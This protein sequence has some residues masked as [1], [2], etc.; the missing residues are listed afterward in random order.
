MIVW[1]QLLIAIFV[2]YI[3]TAANIHH[4]RCIIFLVCDIDILI[5]FSLYWCN[6]AHYGCDSLKL[7]LERFLTRHHIR[8][9]VLS[10]TTHITL[11]HIYYLFVFFVVFFSFTTKGGHSGSQAVR[12]FHLS[13]LNMMRPSKH[14]SGI[15]LRSGSNPWT[16]L[17]TIR[18]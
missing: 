7:I 4:R 15:S 6:L 2:I 1:L 16:R 12:A 3:V 5:Y 10:L 13:R 8:L 18:C 14:L 11:S 17:N 9:S